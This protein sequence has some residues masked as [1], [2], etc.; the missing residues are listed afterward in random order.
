MLSPRRCKPFTTSTR[1]VKATPP[2]HTMPC[3]ETA[4]VKH[5]KHVSAMFYTMNSVKPASYPELYVVRLGGDQSKNRHRK[6][7]Y[8]DTSPRADE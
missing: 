6:T 2:P 4:K 5:F 1:L 8:E 3:S 7:P